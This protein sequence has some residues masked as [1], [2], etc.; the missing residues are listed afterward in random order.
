MQVDDQFQNWVVNVPVRPV[1]KSLN[2]HNTP[3]NNKY[4]HDK[5][6]KTW[7]DVKSHD[8]SSAAATVV[9]GPI[10]IGDLCY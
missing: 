3:D 1:R 8:I 6:D 9:A 5:E 4:R 10:N 7:H 2:E